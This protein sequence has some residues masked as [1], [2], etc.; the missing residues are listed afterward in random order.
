[1]KRLSSGLRKYIRRQKLIIK[2]M[3]NNKEE[4]HRLMRAL[5]DRFYKKQGGE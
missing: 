5:L 2:R 3:A 4:K 1:M